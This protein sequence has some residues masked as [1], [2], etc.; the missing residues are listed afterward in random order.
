VFEDCY[1]IT[2]LHKD[3]ESYISDVCPKLNTK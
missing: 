1:L 3:P 2:L